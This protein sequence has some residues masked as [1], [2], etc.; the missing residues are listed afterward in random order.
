MHKITEKEF[1]MKDFS[2]EHLNRIG[3]ST[4]WEMIDILNTARTLYLEGGNYKGEHYDAKDKGIWWQLIQLLPSSYN[5]TRNVMLNYEVL[6]N[7]YKSRKDH[8]LDEWREFCQWIESLPYSEL[9]IG[10]KVYDTVEY[11]K[12]HPE[13]VEKMNKIAA[14]ANEEMK[15]LSRIFIDY[16][17]LK[18][19]L[20]PRNGI[21][22]DSNNNSIIIN[23]KKEKE[24]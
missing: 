9:I 17:A 23:D 24:D 21:V 5:Q 15:K 11:G 13:F 20:I 12:A 1:T 6:T 14:S 2:C 22:S 16:A 19:Q 3:T 8:K 4:L 18:K 10:F 7:I